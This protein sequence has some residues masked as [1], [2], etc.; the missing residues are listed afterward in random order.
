[1]PGLEQPAEGLPRFAVSPIYNGTG[2]QMTAPAAPSG[3]GQ[4]NQVA[5]DLR[6][7]TARAV[8]RVRVVPDVENNAPRHM[9][10]QILVVEPGCTMGQN[11]LLDSLHPDGDDNFLRDAVSN[12]RSAVIKTSPDGQLGNTDVGG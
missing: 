7:R 11:N 2:L 4:F 12:D 5:N 10:D 6:G 1:M 8:V 9:H 3:S